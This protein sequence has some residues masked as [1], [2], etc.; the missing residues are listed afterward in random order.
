MMMIM[1]TLVT[2]T[3]VMIDDD[4]DYSNGASKVLEGAWKLLEGACMT[5]MIFALHLVMVILV[6][7]QRIEPVHQC[8]KLMHGFDNL[9]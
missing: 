1:L 5:L 8:I 4:E 2:L 7:I 3:M 9:G 6:K